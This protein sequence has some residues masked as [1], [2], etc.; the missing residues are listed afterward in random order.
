MIT[1]KTNATRKPECGQESW[2]RGAPDQVLKATSPHRVSSCSS[3]DSVLICVDS[4]FTR[5]VVCCVRPCPV[6][7]AGVATGSDFDGIFPGSDC[8]A[9]LHQ[10][11][12]TYFGDRGPHSIS[13]PVRNALYRP[14]LAE[15]T[16]SHISTP[17]ANPTVSAIHVL[18]R[19]I[20]YSTFGTPPSACFSTNM[21]LCA[22]R[23]RGARAGRRDRGRRAP[24]GSD[25]WRARA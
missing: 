14:A 17:S 25:R 11:R 10:E 12:E 20:R 1:S 19:L 9:C 7:F 16:H 21:L 15:V 6:A 8:A 5:P 3:L 2:K 23:P 24:R 22:S 4:H 18:D 13:S